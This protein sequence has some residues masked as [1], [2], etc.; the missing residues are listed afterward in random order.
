MTADHKAALARVMTDPYFVPELLA[1]MSLDTLK[2]IERTTDEE[3][4]RRRKSAKR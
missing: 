2:A 4:G 1:M 3:S